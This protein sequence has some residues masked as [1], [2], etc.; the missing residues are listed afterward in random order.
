MEN[1]VLG[2][3]SFIDATTGQRITEQM[4]V[5][6]AGVS[7]RRNFSGY[8]VITRA[9]GLAAH[10]ESFQDPPA[11]PTVESL[12]F[13]LQVED[14][15]RQYLPR[16]FTVELPR[17]PDPD[18]ENAIVKPIE[19]RVYPAPIAQVG[20]RWAI[21]RASVFRQGSDERL[22]GAL[23]RVRRTSDGEVLARALSDERGEALVAVEGIPVTTWDDGEG[24]VIS[25]EVEVTLETIF[26]P[27]ADG[28]PDPD[29]LEARRE[30]L[31]N[32]SVS[33]RLASGRAS[34]ADLFVSLP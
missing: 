18:S 26:D 21:V 34:S 19:V 12:D 6:G 8:Y 11:A 27:D 25:N 14:P 30:S 31:P 32:N 5:S 17:N 2:A 15:R 10:N 33:R 20:P 16:R 29:D 9:D 28:Y 3:I 24:P 23:I 7:L 13:T 1:R 4:T 22:G